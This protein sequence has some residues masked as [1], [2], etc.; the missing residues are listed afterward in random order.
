MVHV[1]PGVLEHR[2]ELH[3]ET[4]VGAFV[5]ADIVQGEISETVDFM[6]FALVYAVLPVNFEK[7]FDER[8]DL[9]DVVDVK[10][11]HPEAYDVGNVGNRGVFGTFEFEF[12]R[13][14]RLRL[15]S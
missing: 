1:G 8:G 3:L 10:G 12:P 6:E 2:A 13:K 7:P 15:N 11:Y 5:A 4:D 9:V 14:R